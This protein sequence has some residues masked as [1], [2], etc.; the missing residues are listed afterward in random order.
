MQVFLSGNPYRSLKGTL[1]VPV[2]K[3]PPLGSFKASCK[4]SFMGSFEGSFKGS[5]ESSFK[6]LAWSFGNW[7]E[8]T[9]SRRC[10]SVAAAELLVL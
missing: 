1:I 6:A 8:E 10:S 4:G 5:V 9:T 2:K 7:E 3:E